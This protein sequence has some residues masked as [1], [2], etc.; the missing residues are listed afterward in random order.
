MGFVKHQI[1][2]VELCTIIIIIIIRPF[3]KDGV[4]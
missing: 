3:L 4:Y 1:F 2:Y